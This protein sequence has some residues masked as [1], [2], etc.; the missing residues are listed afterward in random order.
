MSC[1]VTKPRCATRTSWP[2]IFPWPPATIVSWSSRRTR[3]R[4]RA[5]TR[6]GGRAP[7]LL[8]CRDADVDAPFVDLELGASGAGH[9]V[10]DEELS[11]VAH[12]RRDVLDRVQDPRG[13]L[14]VCDED[15][16]RRV[17]ALLFRE[18]VANE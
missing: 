16:L 8:R 10:E 15:G 18:L 7:R 11:G 6:A 5:S 1:S 2:S 17:L 13:G 9:A 12:D 4:F 14:V 3:M